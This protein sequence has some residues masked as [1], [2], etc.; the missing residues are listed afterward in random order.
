MTHCPFCK[1]TNIISRHAG[2]QTG[3]RIGSVTG[4]IGGAA[5]SISGAKLGSIVGAVGGPFGLAL[6]GFAGALLG[7]IVGVLAALGISAIGIPMPPPPNANVGYTAYIRLE[8][9]TLISSAF[10]G[11]IATVLASLL[12]AYRVTRVQV[13]DAL[14]QNI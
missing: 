11:F 4:A 9:F 7:L 12:P 13:V 1:S 8:S 2:R 14:R 6:G 5:N 3:E 10:V